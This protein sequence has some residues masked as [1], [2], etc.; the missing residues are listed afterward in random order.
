MEKMC[1]ETSFSAQL[2]SM[3]RDPQN[4]IQ[5]FICSSYFEALTN[6]PRSPSAKI[7]N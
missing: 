7:G 6:L 4:R 2:K 5:K 1:N 3:K